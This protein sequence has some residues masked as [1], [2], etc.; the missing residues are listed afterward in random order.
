MQRITYDELIDNREYIAGRDRIRRDMMAYKNARRVQ[1][2]DLVSILF[3][4]HRTLWYQTQEMLRA[5]HITERTLRQRELDVYNE[6]IP[7]GL[8]LAAT[9]FIE[10]PDS[11]QIPAVLERLTGAEEHVVLIID[12]ERFACEAE[13][14]RSTDDKTSSIHYLTIPLGERGLMALEAGGTVEMAVE[15]DRYQA[16]TVVSGETVRELIADLRETS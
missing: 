8:A 14:G 5:E 4:N 9:L 10:I 16:R 6:M 1:L 2:G 11:S 13:P 3:E 12:G 15:H 7:E